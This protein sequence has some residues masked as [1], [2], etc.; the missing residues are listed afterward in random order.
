MTTVQFAFAMLLAHMPAQEPTILG[1]GPETMLGQF[2]DLNVESPGLSIVRP[3]KQLQ[4]VEVDEYPCHQDRATSRSRQ[5][6]VSRAS[7][8]HECG[9]EGDTFPGSRRL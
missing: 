8:W 7:G 2:G 4:D 9:L 3:M 5:N 1:I 6:R